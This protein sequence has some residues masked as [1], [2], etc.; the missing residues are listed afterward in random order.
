MWK[1]LTKFHLNDTVTMQYSKNNIT[2]TLIIVTITTTLTLT[3]STSIHFVQNKPK[4]VKNNKI[5]L[6]LFEWIQ[7]WSEYIFCKAQNSYYAGVIN[8]LFDL[9]EF[10]EF[11]P[12]VGLEQNNTL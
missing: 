12:D 7:I 5:I 2:F 4:V 10:I 6:Q 9:W 1:Q 8:F 11:A 3:W